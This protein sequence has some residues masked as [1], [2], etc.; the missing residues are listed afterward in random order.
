MSIFMYKHSPYLKLSTELS[1]DDYNDIGN[2]TR[3]ASILHLIIFIICLIQYCLQRR[4]I[5]TH[6]SRTNQIRSFPI[7]SIPNY[8]ESTHLLEKNS[9]D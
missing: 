1:N 5:A 3:I 6:I 9:S 2:S 8:S 4:T 7:R